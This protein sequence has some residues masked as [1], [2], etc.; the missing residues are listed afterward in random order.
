MDKTIKVMI[1]DDHPIVRKG[2]F[3]LLDVTPDIEV[4]GEAANGSE[5]IRMAKLLKPDIILMDLVMPG[6]DGTEAIRQIKSDNP[7]I[8]ILVLTSFSEEEK[9]ISAI[10]AGA[11]GYLL[12]DSSSQDLLQAIR[13]IYRGGSVFTPEVARKL[14]REMNKPPKLTS[15]V[16]LLTDREFEVLTLIGQ[17]LTNQEI[18]DELTITRKTVISHVSKILSKLHLSNRTQAAIYAVQKGLVRP[19][20]E[21]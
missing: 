20:F 9:I 16:E 1:I 7:A 6:I 8:R 14:I 5:A 11:V 19:E 15:R 10:K 2:L 3:D 21:E 4:V 18:A 13:D 17:G 12:K